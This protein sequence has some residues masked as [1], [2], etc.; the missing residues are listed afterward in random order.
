MIGVE[1]PRW[2]V[3]EPRIVKDSRSRFLNDRNGVF[4]GQAGER[5]AA[6]RLP[7]YVPW[8]D[9]VKIETAD[10]ICTP[11]EK[12][13]VN[14][15]CPTIT[16]SIHRRDCSL[17]LKDRI[18]PKMKKLRGFEAESVNLGLPTQE[19]AGDVRR[20]GDSRSAPAQKWIV[21]GIEDNSPRYLAFRP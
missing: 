13:I 18:L 8:A 16:P 1:I 10:V 2:R 9:I 11:K 6:K 4:R 14:L 5:P 19:S 21:A 7:G 3:D 20:K 15:N 17:E 12:F